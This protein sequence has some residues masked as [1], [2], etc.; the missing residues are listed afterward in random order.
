M[1]ASRLLSLH[2]EP[3]RL[4]VGEEAI[5]GLLHLPAGEAPAQGWPA[6]LM[7]HGFKGHKAG[8]H[9]LHTLFA[10]H[11]AAQGV[12]VL[13]F[14]FRGYGDS[15][16]DFAEVTP[17]RQL[18]DVSAAAEYLRAHSQLDPERL[19]LLG[20]SLGGMLAALAAG[21]VGPH[22]LALWAPALPE[23]FLQ[24]LPGGRLPAGVQDAQGWP[25][26]R[27]FLQE[28]LRQDPLKAAAAW[29]GVAAV[30]H[31]DADEACPPAW[32]ERYAEALGPGTPLALIEGA[33]HTFNNLEAVQTLY[34]LTARF[35]LGEEL[36]AF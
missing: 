21:E 24:Y 35:L 2:E 15:Q 4:Q 5:F 10:R 16:G 22:R 13:R 19:M 31:G 17:S 11:M 33:D 23:Y 6:L 32:G 3:V 28:M 14:D 8:K 1:T 26:G 18:E 12:G 29:G 27:A 25:L 36:S 34:T 30:L 7:L 9:R 20:H